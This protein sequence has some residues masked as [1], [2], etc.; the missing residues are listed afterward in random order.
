VKAYIIFWQFS[1]LP[2][3]SGTFIESNNLMWYGGT[4]ID[5]DRNIFFPFD[6]DLD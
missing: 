2:F 5:G 4:A 3:V 6:E 1:R